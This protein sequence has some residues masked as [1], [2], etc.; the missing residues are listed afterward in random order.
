[1]EYKIV[2]AA[3]RKAFDA[4]ITQAIRKADRCGSEGYVDL[5]NAVEKVLGDGWPEE[6]YDRL[7][8]AL[9]KDGKWTRFF[10]DLLQNTNREYLNDELSISISIYGIVHGI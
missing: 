3:E 7:R 9:G 2:H 1:M 6:A 10:N 4:A 8:D 5:V